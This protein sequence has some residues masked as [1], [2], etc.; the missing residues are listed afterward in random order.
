[1]RFS[2]EISHLL[3][4][5]ASSFV[6]RSTV[7]GGGRRFTI[8]NK[9]RNNTM[10]TYLFAYHGGKMAET[11]AEQAAAMTAWTNWFGAIGEAVV[12]GGNPTAGA[13][14]V[15]ADG[16][17]TDGGGANPL[18]GYSVVRAADL[19]AAAVL[20]KGCPI[21]DNGGSVEVAEIIEM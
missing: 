19:D 1:M 8:E 7:A 16:S 12:D 5:R 9:R 6:V 20:A 15:A 17:T 18:S 13:K 4:I 11:E 3:S 14:T 2:G 10:P 21:L